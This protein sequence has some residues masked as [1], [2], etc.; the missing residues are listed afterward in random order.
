MV[1]TWFLSQDKFI[2]EF[3]FRRTLEGRTTGQDILNILDQFMTVN[4]IVC[5][6]YCTD[7]ATSMTCKCSGVV[8]DQ[9]ENPQS[10]YHTLHFHLPVL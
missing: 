6:G 8:T 3:L 7:S 9:R 10:C 2:K 1:Y 4:S 5:V